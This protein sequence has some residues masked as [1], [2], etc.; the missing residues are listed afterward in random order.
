MLTGESM[1]VDKQPGDRVIGATI[2]TAGAFEIEAT[3][4][5]AV[6]R[7]GADRQADARRAGVAGADSA[8]GRSHLGGVR[9]R[10][11]SSIA[12]ATFA[13]WMILPAEP[14]LVSALTA[15]VAVLIIACPCAMGLAVPTAVMVASGR[16]AAA[17]VLI[18]GGE[19]LERLAEVDT[20]VFD[21]TGTLTKA[22]RRWWTFAQAW[23]ND[24]DT[25]LNTV[26]AV[27]ARSEHPLAKAIVAF[28]GQ[29]DTI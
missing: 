9:A 8:A 4:V 10:R 18:K 24:R 15:A 26:G 22:R 27:E 20:V 21:K 19:P 16:G 23:A 12:I 11:S 2:N 7:A 3:S 29:S 6:E 5:G 1:P 28:A 14:T 25:V 17:G 13:V